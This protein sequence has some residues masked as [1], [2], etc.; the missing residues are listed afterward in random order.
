MIEKFFLPCN[1]IFFVVALDRLKILLDIHFCIALV[2]LLY[3]DLST[4]GV[5]RN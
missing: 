1:V 3:I 5:D 2:L 4:L